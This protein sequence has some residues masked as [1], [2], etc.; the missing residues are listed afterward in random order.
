[1]GLFAPF[2]PPL[3]P[4]QAHLRILETTDLHVH[5]TPYDYYNDRPDPTVGLAQCGT[6]IDR[7]RSTAPNCLLFDNGDFLQGNP[8]GDFIAYVR[9]MGPGQR[10]PVIEAMNT[11]GYDGAA[12]GNHEFNYGLDYLLQSLSGA[13]FPSV[14]ANLMLSEGGT[15]RNDRLL[16]NPYLLLD[17]TLTD[18]LGIAHPIRIGVI[19]LLPPQVMIWDHKHLHGKAVT[20]DMIEAARAWLPQIREAGADL[21]IAL[22]HS[23]IGPSHHADGMENAAVPLARIDGIDVLLTGH[24]HQIFPSAQFRPSADVDPSN[25]TICGKPAVMA[26]FWGSHVGVVDLVLERREGGWRVA[27]S[28][29]RA[30]PIARTSATGAPQALVAGKA[31]TLN[32]VAKIHAQ[33]LHY[34]RRPVGRRATPLSTYFSQVADTPAVRLVAEAQAQVV[35]KALSGTR[36]ADLPLLSAAAPLKA[37]GPTGPQYYSD[38][39]AGDLAIR[40]IADLYVFPNVV[41]ALKITGA[42]LADWLERAAGMF[43]RIAPG[44]ADARLLNPDFPS[45][46]FDLIWGVGFEIDLSQPSRFTEAGQLAEP[47]ARRIMNLTFEGKPVDMQA[48]Y[49]I[50]TNDYRAH[51]GGAFP[52]TGG[53][54]VIHETTLR[55]RDALLNLIRGGDVPACLP[56]A[57][58]SFAPLPGTTVLF[59]TG[60]ESAAHLADAAALRIEP[61][62]TAPVG[63]QRYRIRL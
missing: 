53:G 56:A 18:G 2:H 28:T 60:S 52:G 43:N 49:V 47:A 15:V 20:R 11:L 25:G 57:T 50:A 21:V 39:P 4:K 31:E 23:G 9:G 46:N 61:A 58:W 17:R 38:V 12:L 63:F 7:L 36:W 42:E 29:S 45:Y 54:K 32:A 35:A 44:A 33:T 10:H 5:V 48:D 59:D 16:T 19:G 13:N 40:H 22:A 27:G 6:L 62:G 1:L 8:M 41:R 3:Q 30:E 26:G 37:G 51:G 24:T 55:N 34:V 14:C